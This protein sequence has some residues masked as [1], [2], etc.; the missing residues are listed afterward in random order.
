MS[1]QASPPID[2]DPPQS[3]SPIGLI[4][5]CKQFCSAQPRRIVFADAFDERAL[6]AASELSKGGYMFPTLLGD[7]PQLRAWAQRH[8]IDL[9]AVTLLDPAHAPQLD[10][11]SK[12][13]QTRL[14]GKRS[15]LEDARRHHGDSLWFAAM[16]LKA[17]DADC[18]V[19]GNL[20]ST[21]DVLRAALRVIG[22]APGT[23]TVSSL[24]FMIAPKTGQ[25]LSFADCS[26]VPRP[27]VAQLADI[28]ISTGDHYRKVTG[29]EPRIAM[30]SF[31]TL[32]SLRHSSVTPVREAVDLIRQRR[33]ELL[34]EGELQFDAAFVPAVAQR[35]VP[36]SVLGGRANVFIFPDLNAGNIAYKIAER[37]GGYSALGPMLQGLA[38]PLHDVSRGC[39]AKD[40]V[41]VA[42]VAMKMAFGRSSP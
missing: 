18:V 20:R 27:N 35:K 4:K 37:L 42:L 28:A 40:M 36:G 17:G 5:A 9:G 15:A 38:K 30:L 32:G 33:P 29:N 14:A 24:F 8:D 11:Y 6:K 2:A 21:P 34:V 7:P 3:A 39:S 22:P 19:A 10:E 41:E 26:V 25:V 12:R 16:M 13:L 23:R 31:S 1:E